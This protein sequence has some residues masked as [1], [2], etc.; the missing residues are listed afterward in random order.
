MP[1]EFAHVGC[2]HDLPKRHKFFD[3]MPSFWLITDSSNAPHY[4][5]GKFLANTLNPSTQNNH[6]VKDSFQASS[7][8]QSTPHT[9]FEFASFDVESLFTGIDLLQEDIQFLRNHKMIKISNPPRLCFRLFDL[10]TP[11]LQ[12]FKNYINPPPQPLTKKANRA[13][14]TTC[15]N[16]HL[17]MPK[18]IFQWF[19]Y[20]PSSAKYKWY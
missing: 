3:D 10:G 8:I 19:E 12:T 15:C 7:R 11:L 1:P 14:I 5:I 20:S 4:K 6:S 18:I 16:Q 9:L 2:A 13:I 17:Y